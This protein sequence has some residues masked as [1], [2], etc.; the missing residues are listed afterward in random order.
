MLFFGLTV[1]ESTAIVAGIAQCAALAPGGECNGF[2]ELEQ[3]QRDVCNKS[4]RSYLE[5]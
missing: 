2:Q 5:Q 1:I 4:L 3:V